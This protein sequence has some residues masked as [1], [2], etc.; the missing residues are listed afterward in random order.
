MYHSKRVQFAKPDGT[1]SPQ[2]LLKILPDTGR[3]LSKGIE[4]ESILISQG[5]QDDEKWMQ[6]G[7]AVSMKADG[8]SASIPVGGIVGEVPPLPFAYMRQSVYE[9]M[10][11]DGQS[12]QHLV[13]YG[14]GD[15][16][17]KIEKSFAD[18]R[19]VLAENTDIKKLREAF[20][21]H[22]KIMV[23]FLSIIALLAVFVGG[24]SIASAI[25]MSIGERRR[26]L[27]AM[28]AIGAG[29]R[30]I[31]GLV[32]VEVMIM[33]AVSW[34]AALLFSYPAAKVAGNEFGRIFLHSDLITTMSLSGAVFWLVLSLTTAIASAF[35]PA[36]RAAKA[37]LRD[38]LTY[39]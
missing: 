16:R 1:Y 5:L 3:L 31:T 8:L 2:Y 39:E 19:I 38:T 37:P 30:D 34:L 7:K 33:A 18:A 24:L 28:R 35:L 12:T 21:D 11:G 9:N 36:T 4:T 10:I 23:N 32:M 20:V 26:E 6:P 27:G 29:R 17:A 15:I 22:L 14:E 25:G 13:L